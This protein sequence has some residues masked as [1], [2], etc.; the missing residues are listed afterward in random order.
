M[1]EE[2]KEVRLN[3][4]TSNL[5]SLSRSSFEGVSR[6]GGMLVVDKNRVRFASANVVAKLVLLINVER[7]IFVSTTILSCHGGYLEF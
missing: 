6:G 2:G 1:F 5:Q 4:I 7:N 3:F